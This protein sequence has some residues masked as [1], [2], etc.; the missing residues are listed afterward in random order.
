M[1]AETFLWVRCADY[2]NLCSGKG[3]FYQ[4]FF[5]SGFVWCCWFVDAQVTGSS[6][7]RF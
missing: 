6:G 5:S 3:V 1:Q 4:I 7:D 2:R